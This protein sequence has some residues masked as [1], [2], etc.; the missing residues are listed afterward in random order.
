MVIPD[1]MTQRLLAGIS[2]GNPPGTA[3]VFGASIAYQLAAQDGLL[4]L[5]EVGEADQIAALK[6]WMDSRHLGPGHL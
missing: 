2:A 1:N 6:D 4:A 5:D 3:V